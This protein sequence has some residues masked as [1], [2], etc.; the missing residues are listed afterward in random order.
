MH[1]PAL[2]SAGNERKSSTIVSLNLIL[3][4]IKLQFEYATPERPRL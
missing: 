2:P 1:S 4:I 3:K